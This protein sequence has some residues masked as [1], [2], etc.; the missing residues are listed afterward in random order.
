MI[1]LIRVLK[2]PTKSLKKLVLFNGDFS[3]KDLN[4]QAEKR[5][6][7]AGLGTKSASLDP[8]DS[9]KDSVKKTLFARYGDFDD[10]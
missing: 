2:G 1:D 8:N 3:K 6:A 9:Y 4:L 7:Q 5:N 10:N